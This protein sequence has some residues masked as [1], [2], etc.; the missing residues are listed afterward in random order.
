MRR[1]IV[2]L[3]VISGLGIASMGAMSV[4][5][6]S[7][8]ITATTGKATGITSHSAVLHGTVTT[9]G[10]PVFWE[11]QYGTTDKYGEATPLKL[12][13]GGQT[14]PKPVAAPVKG[15]SPFTTY[16]Y[17]LVVVYATRGPGPYYY[18]IPGF[19][20]GGD[21]TFR[22]EQTGRFLLNGKGLKA[23]NGHVPLVFKCASTSNCTGKFSLTVRRKLKKSKKYGQVVCATAAF[24]IHA[25]RSGRVDPKLRS[26]CLA[27]LRLASHHRLTAKLTSYPRTGQHALIR[28]VPLSL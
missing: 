28:Q 2:R 16:H 7:A 20:A 8:A 26:A 1:G 15:L 18:P 9:G 12:L 5:S 19:A 25:G 22:T 6:A 23:Q 3:L 24:S 14:A 4:A 17:R 13:P 10:A 27:A 21:L 11:F